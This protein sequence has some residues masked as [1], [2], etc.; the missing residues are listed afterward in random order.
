MVGFQWALLVYKR[1]SLNYPNISQEF[2]LRPQVQ[3]FLHTVAFHET[4]LRQQ[5]RRLRIVPQRDGY[6]LESKQEAT[7]V[8]S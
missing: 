2:I 4:H 6:Q 5:H 8:G 1:V 3:G 7:L